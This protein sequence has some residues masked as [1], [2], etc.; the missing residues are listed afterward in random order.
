MATYAIGDIQG[1][2]A[3]FMELLRRVRFRP[4][5]D[6]LWLVGDVVNRGPRSLDVLRWIADHE[7]DV[8]W[9]LGNHDLHLVAMSL[10]IREEKGRDTFQD[11]LAA[12]DRDLLLKRVAAQPLVHRERGFVMVHA[13]FLPGWTVNDAESLAREA[14]AALRGAG[15]EAAL[16]SIYAPGPTGWSLGLSEQ[17]RVQVVLKALTRVRYVDGQ[18]GMVPGHLGPTQE[19]SEDRIPWFE[20]ASLA[21]EETIVCG[22]WS[23]LGLHVTEKLI[24][25]DSGCVYGRYLSA[26]RLEDRA[27]FQVPGQENS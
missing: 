21:H 19:A 11:V 22:H 13:G 6:R 17:E 10:G 14:E 27:V 24:A 4:G 8:T 16:S 7:D 15:S 12:P 23:T 2:Y 9:V 18:G 1:C 25:L 3:P 20:A 5:D 26:V